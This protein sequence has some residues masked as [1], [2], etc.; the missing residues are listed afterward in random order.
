[1]T[2][3]K[4]TVDP[5]WTDER[6]DNVF[7]LNGND[8]LAHDAAKMRNEYEAERTQLLARIEHLQTGYMAE[9]NVVEQALG[10][11]LGYPRYCDDQV[12]FPGTTE[13]DGVCV[14]EHVAGTIAMEAAGKIVKLKAATNPSDA[15][16][17]AL[18]QRVYAYACSVPDEQLGAHMA[19]AHLVELR[20]ITR[21][22]MNE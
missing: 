15:H 8:E 19:E 22:W 21:E 13:A 16:I 1:M 17:D 4:S 7:W 5:L 2:D 14:G 10:A 11:A 18:F 9:L 6:I 3:E 12:N 20:R